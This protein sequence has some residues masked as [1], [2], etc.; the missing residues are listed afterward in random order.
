MSTYLW[1][2]F[3]I[4]SKI[5]HYIFQQIEIIYTEKNCS[6]L[7]EI[8]PWKGAITKKIHAISDNFIV[9][10]KDDVLI[11]NL[12]EQKDS[13]TRNI[14]HIIHD[15][16]LQ[17]SED[18]L[19]NLNCKPEATLVIWNLPYYITSPILRKFF[20]AG[21][22]HYQAGFFMMQHEVGEKIKAD[23]KKKSYLWRLLNYAYIVEYCKVV[24]AKAF[25]PAPK[26][27]SCL[28]KLTPKT[29]IPALNF[30][31]LISFLDDYAPFSRKTLWAI[32]KLHEKKGKV[33]ITI[34][35]ELKKLRLEEL[36]WETMEM[37][38]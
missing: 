6:T 36:D 24:P 37:I 38:L 16:I 22:Q 14:K 35:E 21:Q 25:K 20:G 2:N 8:G 7:I 31:K 5:K 29:E 3:L 17:V 28:I 26:V 34:P 11:P 12:Q 30:E 1:Q 18:Q 15:D 32:Q 33:V 19:K 4:D 9:I 10:E 13:H 23:T 27:K